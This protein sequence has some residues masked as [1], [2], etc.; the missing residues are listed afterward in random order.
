MNIIN[1]YTDYNKLY[2]GGRLDRAKALWGGVPLLV[3]ERGEGG[4]VAI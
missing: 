1:I 4:S 2:F 3:G